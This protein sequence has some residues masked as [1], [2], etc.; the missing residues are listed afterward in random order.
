[1]ET[2]ATATASK[3]STS[4]GDNTVTHELRNGLSRTSALFL[5]TSDQ[6]RV[7]IFLLSPVHRPACVIHR[8]SA[9]STPDVIGFDVENTDAQRWVNCLLEPRAGESIIKR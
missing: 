9:W 5:E 6:R 8:H 4:Q 1:M 7:K 3:A 2:S